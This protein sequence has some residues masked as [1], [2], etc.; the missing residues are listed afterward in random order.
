MLYLLLIRLYDTLNY[1][2]PQ[3]K[4][5]KNHKPKLTSKEYI[6]TYSSLLLL[7]SGSW[8]HCSY[9]SHVYDVFEV[10][11]FGEYPFYL[12]QY[13]KSYKLNKT[14]PH[15]SWLSIKIFCFFFIFN[16]FIMHIQYICITK[17]EISYKNSY[18]MSLKSEI[19]LQLNHWLCQ[20]NQFVPSPLQI[21]N[22]LVINK[23]L[24]TCIQN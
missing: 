12:F 14:N 3:Q 7:S 13:P 19:K 21:I 4:A 15:F 2:N 1:N 9:K 23:Q 8:K 17:I 24:Q 6:F 11:I 22:C 5:G 10:H 16:N 18:I 20:I